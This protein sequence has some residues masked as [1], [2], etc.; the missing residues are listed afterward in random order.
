[1]K[2]IDFKIK[3][4]PYNPR[5]MSKD[6][7]KRLKL[8]MSEFGDLS[9]ITIN[10]RN[11]HIFTGNHRWKELEETYGTLELVH[12]EDERYSI[13]KKGSKSIGFFAR[14]VD[15]TLTKEK[16]AN[17]V[18]N[19]N[20]NTGDLTESLQDELRE[21]EAD[22]EVEL[23]KDLGLQDIMFKRDLDDEDLDMDET[24]TDL[25]RRKTVED[26]N[27][28][29]DKKPSPVNHIMSSVKI[30]TPTEYKDEILDVVTK[31]LS[32]LG[33]YDEITIS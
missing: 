31:A 23:L 17:I 21:I 3:N 24:Q 8:S 15:W 12:V 25:K 30:T 2:K 27:D 10:A 11:G 16:Q 14:V 18:A 6:N 32:K 26:L 19:L 5:K 13:H 29:D 4:C 28:E 33:F 1:M 7:K 20:S 22:S 9:G